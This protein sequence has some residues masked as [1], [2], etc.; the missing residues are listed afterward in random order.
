MPTGCAGPRLSCQ[1]PDGVRQPPIETGFP[2]GAITSNAGVLLTGLAARRMNL[3]DRQGARSRDHR[4]PDPAER[5]RFLPG[6][7]M[8]CRGRAEDV[9][10]VIGVAEALPPNSWFLCLFRQRFRVF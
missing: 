4:R 8:S 7:V 9:D 3:F 6:S 1:S 10:N 2:G 5:F